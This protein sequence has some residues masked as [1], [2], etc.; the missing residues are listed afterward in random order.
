MPAN[1][2]QLSAEFKETVYPKPIPGKTGYNVNGK[3]E[4]ICKDDTSLMY[5]RFNGTW[6]KIPHRGRVADIP[7]L[8]VNLGYEEDGTLVIMSVNLPKAK[9]Y[10]GAKNIGRIE[11]GAQIKNRFIGGDPLDLRMVDQLGM[12]VVSDLE[13][14]FK[15]GL[16]SFLGVLYAW[17]DDSS[18]VDLTSLLPS[19][20]F[21]HRWAVVGLKTDVEPHELYAAAGDEVLVTISDLTLEMLATVVNDEF[22]ILG[23]IPLCGVQLRYGQSVF[24]ERDFEAIAGV[25]FGG[26]A[27]GGGEGDDTLFWMA[28]G[29]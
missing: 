14:R 18:T 7:H 13:V 9:Q 10:M 29:Y 15:R 20:D 28:G 22:L 1:Y 3:M 12:R 6:D 21:Y 16:Y 4:V 8:D 11:N 27:S 17:D 26:V 19:V 23:Y 24:T 2:D 5:V 25:I